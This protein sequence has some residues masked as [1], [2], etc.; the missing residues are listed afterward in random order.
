[1]TDEIVEKV[2]VARKK[3]AEECGC[4]FRKLVDRLMRLQEEHP[5]RLVDK[6]P[7]TDM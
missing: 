4:D 6:A 3:I 5:E 7:K 2:P 1:M